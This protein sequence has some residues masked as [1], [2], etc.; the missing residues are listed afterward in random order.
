MCLNSASLSTSVE[1]PPVA[2]LNIGCESV[3]NI[4]SVYVLGIILKASISVAEEM[5]TFIAHVAQSTL[6]ACLY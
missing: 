3:Q 5:G 6:L 1:L 2:R 4:I